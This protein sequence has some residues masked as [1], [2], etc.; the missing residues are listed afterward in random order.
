MSYN[1]I[2]K[3]AL[4]WGAVGLVVC[5]LLSP[6]AFADV[7]QYV[8]EQN[9]FIVLTVRCAADGVHPCNCAILSAELVAEDEDPFMCWNIDG[10][11]IIFTNEKRRIEKRVEDIKARIT[12]PAPSTSVPPG[13][14]KPLD[15]PSVKPS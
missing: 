13:R 3:R 7:Y 9:G 10:E 11:K 5:G 6:L 1:G 8:D 12:N 4:R 2:M 14:P 15:S